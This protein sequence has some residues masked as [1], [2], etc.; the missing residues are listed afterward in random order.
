MA[1]ESIVAETA[2]RI[3][4][5]LADPQ[6]LNRAQDDAWMAPAWS[7]LEEA[8]LPLAWVPEEL[9]GGGADL[10]DGFAVLREAGRAAVPLPV[11]ETLLAGWLL[12]Q[13][14]IP[15]PKG[16]MSCGPA[17]DGDTVALAG[18]G[19]LSGRLRAVPLAKGA[20]HLAILVERENG[21]AAV[22][23]MEAGAAQ[24]L[25]GT[26][27]AGDALNA[28]LLQGAR[29]AAV[30]DAPRGLDAGSL[31]L[32]G[33]AGRAMQM[34]GALEAILDL[35]VAYANERIAFGRPIAKFQAVQH[36]L[37]R[38]AGEVA[39]AL[40]AAGSAAEAIAAVARFDEGVLLEAASAKVRV[41]EAAGEGAAIAHQVLGAIGFTR[42]H[43]LHR[44][45]RRLWAWRDDFGNESQWAVKLGRLVAA[46]GADGLWPMLAA[47]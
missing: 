3:F 28:V 44:F 13:A 26:S 45:T 35:T 39:A 43:V 23:L 37:A 16:P 40:A 19:T 41:G 15:A 27:L 20:Q 33:A 21:G 12:T 8:G 29:P 6:T 14:G 22:A 2:R 25:E 38:L 4:S 24:V 7:A 11:A 10:A 30:G 47:R 1:S 34:A 17:R 18:N 9:G 42:E 31:M 32:M 46:K 5:D 36:N